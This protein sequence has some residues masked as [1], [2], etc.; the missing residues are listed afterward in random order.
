MA[1]T[2]SDSEQ[3]V[4]AVNMGSQSAGTKVTVSDS[5]GDTVLT[6]TPELSFSAVIFSSPELVA[7]ETYTVTAGTS[8][9]Q[10]TAK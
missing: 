6:V 2:F 1:Q 5:D 3:G 10:A 8:A 7:G 9:G 4:I